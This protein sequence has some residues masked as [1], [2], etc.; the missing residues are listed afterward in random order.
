MT[1]EPIRQV[2]ADG[3]REKI[4]ALALE[5][6][7]KGWKLYPTPRFYFSD[8]HICLQW[9]NGRGKQS[10]SGFCGYWGSQAKTACGSQPR[11]SRAGS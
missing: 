10:T 6:Y 11:C 2:N 1:L 5:D 8:F 9:G 4:A 7:F 3:K